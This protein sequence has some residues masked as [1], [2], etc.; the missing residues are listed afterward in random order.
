MLEQL[1]HFGNVEPAYI[2]PPILGLQH[3]YRRKA[4]LSV[5]YVQ[6]KEA[7]L[8]GFSEKYSHKVAEIE[9]CAILHPSVGDKISA[10][11]KVIASLK[12]LRAIPQIEVAVGDTVSALVIRHLE[13]LPREDLDLL[14][15]FA[16]AHQLHFYGQPKGPDSL[17]PIWPESKSKDYRLSYRF[18]AYD[19]TMRF[20]PLDFTQIHQEINQQMVAIAIQLLDPKPTDHILDLYCGLGNF[21][22]PLARFAKTV[23]GIEGS[24]EMVE[25][26]IEN[27]KYNQISN[28]EFYEADLNLIADPKQKSSISKTRPEWQQSSY[29]KVLIDPARSGAET[30]LPFIA[31]CGAKRIVYVSCNPATFARDIGLLVNEHGFR[32]ISAGIMDMFPHTAHV[33][34]IALLEK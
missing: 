8:I 2:L 19:V 26:A 16:K 27:A 1:K 24:K 18:P 3:Q 31:N 17:Y 13:P 29:D 15:A 30:I 4:R 9:S 6:K 14:K 21:T 28:A 25:R 23:V 22:L 20:H 5:R 10:L 32:L 34:S 11:K 33:E 12:M 7:L